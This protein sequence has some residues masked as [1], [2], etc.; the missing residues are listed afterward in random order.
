MANI[1]HNVLNSD[2][3]FWYKLF[4]TKIDITSFSFLKMM[5]GVYIVL[6]NSYFMYSYF[7]VV[8]FRRFSHSQ[9]DGHRE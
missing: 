6:I 3:Y 1:F 7:Y 9:E 4:E 2:D 5:I 8:L